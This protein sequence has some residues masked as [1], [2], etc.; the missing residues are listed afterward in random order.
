MGASQ[1]DQ[2]QTEMIQAY[3]ARIKEVDKS[4]KACQ[5]KMMMRD[6]NKTHLED[7]IRERREVLGKTSTLVREKN[8]EVLACEAKKK[9]AKEASE[10][11]STKEE[12]DDVVEQI[13]NTKQDLELA[14]MNLTEAAA[15]LKLRIRALRLEQSFMRRMYAQ[16]RKAEDERLKQ[17][18]I[19]EQMAASLNQLPGLGE[20]PLNTS[21]PT[22]GGS[23][24]KESLVK[25]LN[26]E[27]VKEN[28]DQGKDPDEDE[29]G[30]DLGSSARSS[31]RRRRR[32]R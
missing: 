7:E 15:S 28:P 8:M 27:L 18:E 17:E 26:E 3:R 13:G 14:K 19:H 29:D 22:E 16:Q 1:T 4:H 10:T 6:L 30:S 20:M 12:L 5:Q 32:R 25:M 11:S 24:K 9:E 23:G 21:V 2:F 31:S